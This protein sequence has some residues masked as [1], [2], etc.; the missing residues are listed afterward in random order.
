MDCGVE[1]KTAQRGRMWFLHKPVVCIF[2]TFCAGISTF[3]V[4]FNKSFEDF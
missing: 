3:S 4:V 1:N 2:D